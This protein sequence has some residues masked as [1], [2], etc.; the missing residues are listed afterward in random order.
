[1]STF[2]ED[3]ARQENI[4]LDEAH[5]TIRGWLGYKSNKELWCEE[6]EFDEED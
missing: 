6:H 5:Q 3:Y 1:M 4:S 2:A